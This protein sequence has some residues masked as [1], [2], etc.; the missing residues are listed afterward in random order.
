MLVSV[1]IPA[2]NVAG[3]L[4]RAIDSVLAQTRQGFEIVVV[5]DASSDGT[6]DLVRQRAAQDNRIKLLQNP[7]NAGPSVARN[8][9]IAAAR[10][11]W[12]AVLD[13]DD[14][15]EPDRL[16]AL[17]AI[18]EM[19][20]A[21]MVADN[22]VLYDAVADLCTGVAMPDLREDAVDIVGTED[23][24]RN[25]ITARSPFDYGQLKPVMR[26]S[27]LLE[28]QLRYPDD[29]RHGEDF[30]LYAKILLSGGRFVLVGKPYYLFTQRIGQVSGKPSGFSR[31]IV[32]FEGMRSHTLALLSHPAVR[33][34]AVREALMRERA[35]AILWHT[36]RVSVETFAQ[37]RNFPGLLRVSLKD[38]RIP[39]LVARRIVGRLI[40]AASARG[41]QSLLVLTVVLGLLKYV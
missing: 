1:I 17:C 28:Q 39:V 5:D 16:E 26:R 6:A 22:L 4:D 37:S 11:E 25:C 2:F 9:G 7:V 27:F 8:R 32:S 10:G 33:S 21:Q 29:L 18:G 38:W 20:Q 30:V 40:R 41:L 24:L 31:T 15:Y 13:A 34:N 12:V 35:S 23:F 19:K 3:C 14:A 36:S